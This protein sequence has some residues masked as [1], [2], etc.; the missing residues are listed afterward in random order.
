[1]IRRAAVAAVAAVLV[2]AAPARADGGAPGLAAAAGSRFPDRAFALTLPDGTGVRPEQIRV[3]ENG[4]PVSR[5]TLRSAD[6]MPSSRFGVVLA[7]DTSWSMHGRPLRGAIA[8]ARTFIAHR[9]PGQP[10]AL[11]TF[12]GDIEVNQP[13]TTDGAALARASSTPAAGPSR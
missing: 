13:F 8:A 7:I 3:F 11:M 2:A 10:V 4:K 1:V 5:V 6:Q 12:G 9:S